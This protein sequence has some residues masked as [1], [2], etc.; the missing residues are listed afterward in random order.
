MEILRNTNNQETVSLSEFTITQISPAVKNQDRVNI[1][2]NGKYSFSL[3]ITQLVDYKIKINQKITK[4]KLE[5]YKHASTFGKLY[6]RTLEWVLT[7]PHSIK[8]TRDYL[9]RKRSLG[10]EDIQLIIDR[11]IAKKY[12]DD[13]TFAEHYVEFYATK[14]GASRKRLQLELKKKGIRNEIIE[15]VLAKTKRSDEDEIKKIIL[16]KRARYDDEKL[17]QYLIRQGFDFELVKETVREMDSQS[18]E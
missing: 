16:K 6:Q 17:I 14:K 4:E 15:E 13:Y 8:E 11:L 10:S 7:R 3:N 5:E 1:Y 18:L 12:L 9:I 2:V